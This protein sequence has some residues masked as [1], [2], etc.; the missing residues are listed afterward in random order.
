MRYLPLIGAFALFGSA[1]GWAG[2]EVYGPIAFGIAIILGPFIAF[3]AV[4][5]HSNARTS[6]VPFLR[7][8]L[9]GLILA[10]LLWIA[11]TC[12]WGLNEVILNSGGIGG[13]V[14]KSALG[15]LLGFVMGLTVAWYVRQPRKRWARWLRLATLSL[16]FG[17]ALTAGVLYV[18][19]T[20]VREPGRYPP[21]ESSPYKLPWPA[22]QK[23]LCS[24]GN[25]GIVSHRDHDIYAFDFAMPIG[26]PICAARAGKVL[27]VVDHHDGNGYEW[28]GN[29]VTIHHADGTS[30]VY[31]HVRKQGSR[32][33]VG[34]SVQQ[35]QIIADSGNVGHSTSPH[36]HFEVYDQNWKSMPISFTDV[37]TSSGVPRMGQRYVSGNVRT[38]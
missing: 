26:S 16:W 14:A 5:N 25:W 37:P 4:S 21:S 10:P 18:V 12:L 34:E 17:L 2:Q 3:V 29:G 1:A 33:K 20:G 7:S 6:R 22:G 30:A 38:Q 27:S 24:Q 31:W 9:L 11:G 19:F 36:L 28:P 13:P 23:W 15:V 32:V 8:I 35:G